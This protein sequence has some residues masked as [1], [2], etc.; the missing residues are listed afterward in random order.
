MFQ[1]WRHHASRDADIEVTWRRLYTHAGVDEARVAWDVFIMQDGQ[2]HWH[3]ECGQ[4]ILELFRNLTV[5]VEIGGEKPDLQHELFD[6]ITL[7]PD[8][9]TQEIVDYIAQLRAA[10]RL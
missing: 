8:S 3:C 1:R 6:L 4:P 7:M 10:R 2:E 9:Q 5:T